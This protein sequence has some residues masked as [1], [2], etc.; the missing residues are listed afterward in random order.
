[1][2]NSLYF[3]GKGDIYA[4]AMDT[5]LQE[6]GYA[7]SDYGSFGECSVSCGGFCTNLIFV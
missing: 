2:S 4:E 3:S 1:M 7:L 6:E 5:F